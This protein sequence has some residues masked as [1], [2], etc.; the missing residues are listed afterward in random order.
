MNKSQVSLYVKELISDQLF[1][2]NLYVYQ[3]TPV[4]VMLN[5][6]ERINQLLEWAKTTPRLY[7][8]HYINKLGYYKD[9]NN[10]YIDKLKLRE[11]LPVL[12]PRPNA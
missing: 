2:D 6:L 12:P 10:E 11:G 9:N 4:N 3:S 8:E 1:N 5:N 7:R